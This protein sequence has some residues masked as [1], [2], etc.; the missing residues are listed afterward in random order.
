[1]DTWLGYFIVTRNKDNVNQDNWVLLIDELNQIVGV[2]NKCHERGNTKAPRGIVDRFNYGTEEAP[3]WYSNAYL[4]VANFNV[5]AIDFDKFQNRLVNLFDVPEHKVTYTT[6][7]QTHRYRLSVT[8]TYAVNDVD[9]ITVE[10]L[11]CAADDQLCTTEESRQEVLAVLA[12]NPQAWGEGV[13]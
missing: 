3:S 4:Y 10:L 9:R 7:T 5:G 6:A 1:M 12:A 2:G 11:G 13:E 8:A